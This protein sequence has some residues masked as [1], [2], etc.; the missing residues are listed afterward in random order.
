VPEKADNGGL[1]SH[2]TGF[3]LLNPLPRFKWICIQGAYSWNNG[4]ELSRERYAECD[5]NLPLSSLLSRS[6]S[7]SL[8]EQ[9][10][11]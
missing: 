11:K 3:L 4:R 5:R 7:T 6:I 9:A 10:G 2:S 1:L 8:E